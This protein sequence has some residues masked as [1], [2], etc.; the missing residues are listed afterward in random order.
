MGGRLDM[1]AN[2]PTRGDAVG[3]DLAT[4]VLDRLHNAVLKAGHVLCHQYVAAP[5]AVFR[6]KHGVVASWHPNGR[7]RCK[8][9]RESKVAWAGACVGALIAAI[10]GTAV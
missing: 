10:V 1:L 8:G 2:V 7:H 4:K 5:E 9:R 6:V 3:G